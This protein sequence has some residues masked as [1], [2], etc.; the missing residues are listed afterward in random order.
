MFLRNTIVG[1]AYRAG[2]GCRAFS[3]IYFL[4]KEN[5]VGKRQLSIKIKS[6]F[7]Y[8]NRF[9]ISICKRTLLSIIPLTKFKV[10]FT[11]F[12]QLLLI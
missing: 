11:N 6:S 3:T 4:R 9:M 7:A 1:N 2:K 5:R 10:L 8:F 12:K